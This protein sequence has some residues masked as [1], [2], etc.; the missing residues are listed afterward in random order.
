MRREI[1]LY[2]HSLSLKSCAD[3][4]IQHHDD[5]GGIG[6]DIIPCDV[7][8]FDFGH[9]LE[10]GR[11]LL[12]RRSLCR[13]NGQSDG[14]GSGVVIAHTVL[15]AGG[16]DPGGHRRRVW[17]FRF[18]GG[19]GAGIKGDDSAAIFLRDRI[20]LSRK[21][22]RAGVV[23]IGVDCSGGET[24]R[25]SDHARKQKHLAEGEHVC[26]SQDSR[27]FTIDMVSSLVT[28]PP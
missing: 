28:S 8:I 23:F 3:L 24:R 4:L 5:S 12:K 2:H 6:P 1:S 15:A 20:Q 11:N 7:Q 9:A 13:F 19:G 17:H 21:R 25:H 18:N 16:D 14:V 10:V 27:N 26:A 22:R